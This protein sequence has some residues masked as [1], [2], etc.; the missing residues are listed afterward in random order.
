MEE[1]LRSS[2]AAF[3]GS[4]PT[5]RTKIQAYCELN[6]MNRLQFMNI[7]NVLGLWLKLKREFT[8]KNNVV[9]VYRSRS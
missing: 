5:L 4:N 2:D 8:G 3:V 1:D 7:K 9:S 6:L